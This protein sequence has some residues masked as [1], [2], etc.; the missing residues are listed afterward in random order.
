MCSSRQKVLKTIVHCNLGHAR[1]SMLIM[2]GRYCHDPNRSASEIGWRVRDHIMANHDLATESVL[3][4]PTLLLTC[5]SLLHTGRNFLA[6]VS[7]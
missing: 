4:S 5:Q 3:P 7:Q 2:Y 6:P 1:S